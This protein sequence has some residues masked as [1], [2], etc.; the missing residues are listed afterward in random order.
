ML[1]SFVLER[2][3][4]PANFSTG[5][6]TAMVSSWIHVADAR[7]ALIIYPSNAQFIYPSNRR[8]QKE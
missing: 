3:N 6:E 2:L 7:D 1:S 5:V 4:S 8:I